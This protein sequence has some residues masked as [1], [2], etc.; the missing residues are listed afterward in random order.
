MILGHGMRSF[1]GICGNALSASDVN[2]SMVA[3]LMSLLGY[4]ANGLQLFCRIEETLVA[5]RNV[6]VHLDSKNVAVLNLPNNAFSIARL[7]TPRAN[8]HKVSPVLL[9]RIVG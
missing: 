4:S 6:I 2:K 7:Q 3:R 5:A 9:S 1:V 8:A